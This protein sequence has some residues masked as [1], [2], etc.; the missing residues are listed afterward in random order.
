MHNYFKFA[1]ITVPLRFKSSV[2][3]VGDFT[4]SRL[5]MWWGSAGRFNE[6]GTGGIAQALSHTT[7][8]GHAIRYPIACG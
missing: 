8:G 6:L 3:L 5:M 4:I 2:G 7:A 1:A